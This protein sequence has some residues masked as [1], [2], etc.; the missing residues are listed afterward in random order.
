MKATA[1]DGLCEAPGCGKA[2]I[3]R[4]APTKKAPTINAGAFFVTLHLVGRGDLNQFGKLLIYKLNDD[5]DF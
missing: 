4:K 3:P 1:V 2:G 5:F